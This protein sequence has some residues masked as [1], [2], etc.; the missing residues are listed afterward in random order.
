MLALLLPVILDNSLSFH[1][2]RQRVTITPLVSSTSPEGDYRIFF[3]YVFSITY[4]NFASFFT[5]F[6]FQDR[7]YWWID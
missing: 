6:F 3:L 5:P 7:G 4:G 1:Q 2:H